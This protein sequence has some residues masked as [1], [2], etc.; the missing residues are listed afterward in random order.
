L[1][2]RSGVQE[3][4]RAKFLTFINQ[5]FAN[6]PNGYRLID[7]PEKAQFIMHAFVLNL[8]K[9]S[10]TAAQAALNQGYVGG[11]ILAGAAIGAAVNHNDRYAG[12]GVGGL[13]VGAADFVGSNLVKDVYYMLVADIK[14]SE[15]T[16]DDKQA[17]Q[18]RV[19]TTANKV[20]LKLEQASDGMFQ[21]TAYAI[22]SFF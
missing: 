19:V 9:T 6:N 15:K 1:E 10:E 2:V 21:K 11:S 17:Y 7:N 20:N 8:E 12:A 3:F 18:T 5:E 14:I 13:A 16:K 22:S 4:D